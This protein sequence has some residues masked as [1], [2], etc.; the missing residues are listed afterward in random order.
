MVALMEQVSLG[1]LSLC[2]LIAKSFLIHLVK[3]HM[4][5]FFWRGGVNE[6]FDLC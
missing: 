6:G 3:C 2:L 4:R 5:V 1:K